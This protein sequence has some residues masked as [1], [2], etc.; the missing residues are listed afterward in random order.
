MNNMPYLLFLASICTPSDINVRFLCDVTVLCVS[1][2]RHPHHH[3]LLCVTVVINNFTV[4]KNGN[5]YKNFIRMNPL[6]PTLK[7]QQR[8]GLD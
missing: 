5:K 1:H 4:K 7:S 2:C 6:T 8:S 3:L